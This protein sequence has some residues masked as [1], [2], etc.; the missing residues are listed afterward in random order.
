MVLIPR[1][2]VGSMAYPI[3]GGWEP[4]GLQISTD[5]LSNR[6]KK[7]GDLTALDKNHP[8]SKSMDVI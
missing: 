4:K 2:D 3:S 8:T 6:E 1:L 7:G 5:F